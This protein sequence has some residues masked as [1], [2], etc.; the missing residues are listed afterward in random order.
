MRAAIPDLPTAHPLID[1]LP[2][3]Y[4]E[5]DFLHRFLGALDEVLAPVL[6]VLDNLPAHLDSRTAP[7]DFLAWLGQW[8]AVETDPRAPEA[9]RREVIAAA[10]AQ[11][12]VRGSR[13]GLVRAVRTA[14]GVEPEIGENGGTT[15]SSTPGAA[16]PGSPGMGVTV[17]LRV[18]EPERI[19]RAALEKLV[20]GEV[21]AHVAYRIEILPDDTPGGPS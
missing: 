5:Q 18:P 1:R 11:H 13:H 17:R 12:R 7:A 4:Q 2:A 3:V 6:L 16:L 19:D 20:A 21:P 9:L 15:W 10:V 8:A 14:T